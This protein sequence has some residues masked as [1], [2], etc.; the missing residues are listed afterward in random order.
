[1]DRDFALR[2]FPSS[3]DMSFGVKSRSRQGEKPGTEVTSLVLPGFAV[4]DGDPEEGLGALGF[5]HLIN[6]LR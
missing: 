1:M 4:G 6:L 3:E 5:F 2:S